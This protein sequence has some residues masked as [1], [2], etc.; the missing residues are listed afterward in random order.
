[1]NLEELVAKDLANRVGFPVVEETAEEQVEGQPNEEVQ[2]SSLTEEEDIT[3]T[4]NS[5][6]LQVQVLML[7]HQISG[8]GSTLI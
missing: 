4:P 2:E 8:S 5:T 1:M 7:T 3:V 6:S